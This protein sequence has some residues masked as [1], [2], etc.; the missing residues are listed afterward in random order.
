MR[1]I[2]LIPLVLFISCGK[3]KVETDIPNKI[4]YGVDF[5]AGARFCDNRY[6]LDNIEA[7]ACFKDY[8]TYLSPKLSIDFASIE[9]FCKT[10]YTTP[11]SIET[12]KTDLLELITGS[13]SLISN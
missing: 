5:E 13:K 6:P 3:V 9:S 8:R 11:A 7:E 10:N 4:V 2:Y 12:C 1:L